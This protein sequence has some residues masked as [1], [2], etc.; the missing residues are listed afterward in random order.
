VQQEVDVGRW[1]RGAF[2]A[3]GVG[4][5]VCVIAAVAGWRDEFF[6]AYLVAFNVCAGIAVG[7]L[8]I[9]MLQY[10]TGGNWGIV[11][12]RPLEAGTRTLPLVAVL[13]VPVALG[14]PTLYTW[15]EPAKW[16]SNHHLKEQLEHLRPYLNTGFFLARTAGYFVVWVGLAWLLNHWARKHDE[17]ND[18]RILENAQNL[19]GPGLVVYVL[20]VSF[21]S[22]DWVMSLEPQWY[23]TIYGAMFGMGQVLGAFAFCVAVLLLLGGSSQLSAA[24]QKGNLRDL[25][26]LMLAFVMVW[27]YLS[28]S[29]FLLIWSGNLPEEVPWYLARLQDGWVYVALALVLFHFALPFVLL[30]MA[31]LKRNRKAL[32]SVALLVLFMHVVNLFWLIVPAFTRYEG[33]ARRGLGGLHPLDLAALVGVGG[34]W[35][36][37]FLWQ[38]RSRP[39]LPVHA[40]LAVEEGSHHG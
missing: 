35:L 16:E 26:S 36:G 24:M 19:S 2:S 20:T 27:A 12:R 9:L 18:P 21:A 4:L 5:G 37:A 8:A 28:F 6:R 38:V 29:Q 40:R 23:S 3:G 39:L 17:T 25:G 15:A 30:L 13:F 31:D 7:C 33:E 10:L 32:A 14:L 1:Q 34:V 22:I 11:L